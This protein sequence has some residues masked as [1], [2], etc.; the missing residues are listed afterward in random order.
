MIKYIRKFK[1]RELI[2]LVLAFVFGFFVIVQS[3][4]FRNANDIFIRDM[5][6][7]I[8]QEIKIL[9]EQNENLRKETVDLEGTLA[10]LKDQ[11]QALG[12]IKDQ[13]DKYKKLDGGAPVFGSGISVEL[14]GN[15][16]TPWATDFINE[17]FNSG[18]QTVSINGIRITNKTIG[19]DTLPKGQIVLN[20]SIISSPYIFNAIGDSSTLIKTLE[21]PN[22]ILSRI[23]SAFKDLK[24]EITPKEVIHME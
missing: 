12:A 14:R 21:M 11:N 2:I 8:F 3:R 9:K 23:K 7:N 10:Q 13:I 22:G 15:I 20:G 1:K 16:T 19:F 5:Q 24:T 6:S 4:S 18:A 17:L